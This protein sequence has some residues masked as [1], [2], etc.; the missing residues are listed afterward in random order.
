MSDLLFGCNVSISAA[1]G[2]DPVQDARRAEDSGFDFVSANDHPAAGGSVREA[3]TLLCWIAAQTQSIAVVPRVLAVPLRLPALVAKASETLDR[4]SGGRVILALGSG[5]SPDELDQLGVHPASAA[6][7]T[8]GLEESLRIVRGLWKGE[9]FS[10][11]GQ[12]YRVENLRLDPRPARPIPVWLGTYG[13]RGLVL[14][15]ALADGWL[16]SLGYVEEEK[17][18]R[19]RARVIEAA[20]ACGRGDR[21][22]RCLLNL[23]VHLGGGGISDPGSVVG[24]SQ[25]VA[26]RLKH[27]VGLGFSGFNLVPEG[28]DLDVQ[29]RQLGDE[30]LPEVRAFARSV[31]D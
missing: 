1:P 25:Q 27:F 4:L 31:A 29:V 10:F 5:G 3:W 19:M 15:G 6:E 21:D 13:R 16:P 18:P 11:S 8:T 14:A 17:L 20:V 22:V 9:L 26:E 2:S 24:D 28:V 23:R 7:R 12:V 30:V